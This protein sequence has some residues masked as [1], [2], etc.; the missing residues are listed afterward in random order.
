M[1]GFD[2]DDFGMDDVIELDIQF[3]LF[4]DDDRQVTLQIQ[5]TN[6][7]YSKKSDEVY[8]KIEQS[9]IEKTFHWFIYFCF[10]I[11]SE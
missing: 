8:K 1:F 2:D 7:A 5:K 3:G 6:Q 9:I 11:M 10:G 4:E